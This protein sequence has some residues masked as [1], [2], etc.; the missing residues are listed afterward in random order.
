MQNQM[1]QLEEIKT[2]DPDKLE[3][4]ED[5][6]TVAV[7]WASDPMVNELDLDSV[8]Q[9]EARKMLIEA[10]NKIVQNKNKR[11]LEMY[12]QDVADWQEFVL[13]EENDGKNKPFPKNPLLLKTFNKR[14]INE[15]VFR[16]R[17]YGCFKVLLEKAGFRPVK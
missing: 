4:L 11:R 13:Q 6:E 3:E 9:Q 8:N 14:Q 10:M 15:A 12:R 5:Y 16:A 2:L 7:P 1:T 17:Q